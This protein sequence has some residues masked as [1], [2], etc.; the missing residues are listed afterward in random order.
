MEEIAATSADALDFYRR[1]LAAQPGRANPGSAWG[2]AK[3]IKGTP[4]A[5]G[6]R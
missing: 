3:L 4:A 1:L 5:E 6:D 2:T